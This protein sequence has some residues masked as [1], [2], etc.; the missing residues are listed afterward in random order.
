MVFFAPAIRIHSQS[1][2][3][4]YST[5]QASP[6]FLLSVKPIL[7]LDRMDTLE[8]PLHDALELLW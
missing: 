7:L 2:S 8:R 4:F 3:S 5:R 1:L 6:E